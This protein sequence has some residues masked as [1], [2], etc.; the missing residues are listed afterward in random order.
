M[1]NQIFLFISLLFITHSCKSQEV[2]SQNQTVITA[3]SQPKVRYA[4]YWL[5]PQIPEDK[6][7]EIAKYDLAI[8][9]HENIFNNKEALYKIKEINPNITILCYFNP[10]EIFAPEYLRIYLDRPFTHVVY[11][12]LDATNKWWLKN[13][14]GEIIR[15]DDRQLMLNLSTKSEKFFVSYF[16][17]EMQ[18]WEFITQM[19]LDWIL[20]DTIW[21]GIFEDNFETVEWLALK[22]GKQGVDIDGDKQVDGLK[23]IAK[24]WQEGMENRLKMILEAHSNYIIMGNKG[25]NFLPKYTQGKMFENFPDMYLTHSFEN[26]NQNM[27]NA[28]EIDSVA[29]FNVYSQDHYY[30]SF[31][32]AM[33]VNEPIYLS[34]KQQDV[35][36]DF[37]LNPDDWGKPKTESISEFN[38]KTYTRE[39]E[40]GYVQVIAGDESNKHVH[41]K[42]VLTQETGKLVLEG[43]VLK[44]KPEP[45]K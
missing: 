43:S 36:Q 39:F 45:I 26:Y 37:Y 12:Y 8:I 14:K 22:N 20:E 27:I 10:M 11:R 28:L 29:I 23:E 21:D 32:S 6:V 38:Q 4:N 33:L 18:Y 34:Y 15:F 2:I 19:H 1:K 16:D 24:Y 35:W 41:Y 9:D 7:E 30:L 3:E 31:A 17:K 42:I 44:Q 40:N 13:A 25:K 5:W